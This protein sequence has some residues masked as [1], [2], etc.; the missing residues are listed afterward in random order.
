MKNSRRK[1]EV[2]SQKH[3]QLLSNFQCNPRTATNPQYFND[4]L[5]YNAYSDLTSGRGVT[6]VLCKYENDIP[7]KIC[8]YI[9]LRS[10]VF[11]TEI[12]NHNVTGDPAVEISEL[13]V[14]KKLRAL[15]LR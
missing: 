13:A 9:T 10:S 7:V 12:M 14:D 8:A 11:I 4:Y 1:I 15:R 6:H 2:L 3:F 5:Q